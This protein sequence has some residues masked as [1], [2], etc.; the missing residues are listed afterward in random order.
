MEK[1]YLRKV[2]EI[3][4]LYLVEPE[5]KDIYVEGPEEVN[6]FELFLGSSEPNLISIDNVNFEESSGNSLKSNKE[7]ILYLSKYVN[8]IFGSQLPYI[9]FIVDRDFDTI[10][11]DILN[12]PNLEYTDFANLEMYF[13]NMESI[14]KFL[15]IGLKNFPLEAD[16][17][18]DIFKNILLDLFAL[19]HSRAI[20]DSSYKMLELDKL[21]KIKDSQ[22]SYSN[23]ELLQKFLSKN[24]ALNK[25]SAFETEIENVNNKYKEFGE[26]RFFA[27]G[28]DF[29]E[30]FFIL[31]KKVK[32][33]YSF[34]VKSFTRAFFASIELN[35]LRQYDLF[36][37]MENKY[38]NCA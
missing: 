19:R 37:K 30:L 5:L 15:K 13:F 21:I 14:N 34:N 23:E 1:E 36:Q 33:T 18:V 31:I 12:I 9:T 26:I 32:N 6:F 38:L 35:S 2:I 28:K 3:E 7:K 11:G 4:A 16:H 8:S 27:H 17:I 22:I 25:K 20:I 24:S 10:T 29:F